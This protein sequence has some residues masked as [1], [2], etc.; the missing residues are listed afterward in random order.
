MRSLLLHTSM[1]LLLALSLVSC[2]KTPHGV[3][4][5]N[6]M[7]DLIVDLQ[8]ADAYIDTHAAEYATDSS[9]LVLKQSVFKKHGITSQDYDSS[10]VWYAH[11]MED[12]TK[13]HDKA[14]AIL[15]KRYDK[16]KTGGNDMPEE[17]IAGPNGVQGVP[18]RDAIPRNKLAL[19]S[20]KQASTD[21]KADTT[22]L[23]QGPRSYMLTQGS[24]RGFITFDIQPDAN[25]KRGDRYQLAYNLNRGGNEFKVS[26]NIDYTDGGTAQI[27]RSTN[28]DGWVAIDVQSDTARQVRRIYGYVSYDIKRGQIAYVDSLMLIRTHLN[29]SNYGFIHAQRLLERNNKS[30]D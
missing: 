13:A 20:H 30:K 12:Y 9:K 10:M 19:K 14:V 24:Q 15:Q 17:M 25:K 29:M 23:W 1:L 22:D 27:T 7:A 4:S 3:L 28:S 16:I 5:V 26:L 2:D 8:L 11:N 18:S 6:D 21:T